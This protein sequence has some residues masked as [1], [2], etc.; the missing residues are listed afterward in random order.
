MTCK[1]TDKF[2]GASLTSIVWLI[3][4]AILPLTLLPSGAAHAVSNSV[5]QACKSDYIAY[6]SN[7]AVG[8]KGLRQCMR[9]ASSKLS[10]RCVKALVDAG[11][12]SKSDRARY[13][14]RFR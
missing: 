7:H 13:A 6:C 8:S 3:S 2:S 5:K 10:T 12:V 1:T 4:V 9:S 14:K 11:E